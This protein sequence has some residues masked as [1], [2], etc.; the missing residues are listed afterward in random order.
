MC[1][2][3]S[4]S[5]LLSF[6]VSITLQS[7]EFMFFI[8]SASSSSSFIIFFTLIVLLLCVLPSFYYATSS[9]FLSF[10]FTLQ[11]LEFPAF[12]IF[13]S[14][15]PLLLSSPPPS[16]RHHHHRRYII[17]QHPFVSGSRHAPLAAD[18]ERDYIVFINSPIVPLCPSP[19]AV[20]LL[21][22]LKALVTP[23][24]TPHYLL[25]SSSHSLRMLIFCFHIAVCM[26]TNRK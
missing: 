25:L 1:S 9:L 21:G 5:Y 19:V 8:S 16:R 23:P 22:T 17:P 3:F 11:S 7:L 2:I 6:S 26:V 10:S 18:P 4:L 12:F 24:C 13:H 20:M 14:F 15:I